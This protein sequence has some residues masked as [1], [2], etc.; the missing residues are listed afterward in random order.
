MFLFCDNR[1]KRDAFKTNKK[2]FGN[3]NTSC[4]DSIT[5]IPANDWNEAVKNN[6]AFLTL[7]YLNILHKQESDSFR[8]RYVIVYNRKKP[9]GVV[10]FQINDFSASIPFT[11]RLR[12][13][14]GIEAIVFRTSTGIE[15]PASSSLGL[16][17]SIP[18]KTPSLTSK[19]TLFFTK[20]ALFVSTTKVFN[21]FATIIGNVSTDSTIFGN[22]QV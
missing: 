12:I 22:V 11:L 19:S 20:A 3:F 4:F 6:N 13:S 18:V 14:P 2:L 15:I 7:S 1:I 16:S 8:F 10:Y 5:S 9:I 17:T 21:G